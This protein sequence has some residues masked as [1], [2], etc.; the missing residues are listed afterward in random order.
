[1][2]KILNTF[3][4]NDHSENARNEE[5]EIV[6]NKLNLIVR[7]NIIHKQK[8]FQKEFKQH[9]PNTSEPATHRLQ[10][11]DRCCAAKE[12]LLQ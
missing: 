7:R 3:E 2:H 8:K 5:D 4:S 6:V 9:G 12:N 11:T 10:H 1:M